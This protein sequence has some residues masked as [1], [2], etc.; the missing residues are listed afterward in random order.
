[1]PPNHSLLNLSFCFSPSH[2]TKTPVQL[3]LLLLLLLLLVVVVVVVVEL[4]RDYY[5]CSSGSRLVFLVSLFALRSTF[6]HLEDALGGRQ[7]SPC[8]S[9]AETSPHCKS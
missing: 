9:S 6:I 5:N 8:D 2:C 4:R 3:L 7:Q 1:M